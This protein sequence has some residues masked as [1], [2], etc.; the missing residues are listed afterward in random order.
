MAPSRRRRN[1]AKMKCLVGKMKKEDEKRN[2]EELHQ[3]KVAQM[4]ESAEGKRWTLAQDL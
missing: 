1:H 2:I 3:Q 4:I